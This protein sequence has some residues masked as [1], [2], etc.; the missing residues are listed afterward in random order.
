MRTD[1][2]HILVLPCH[3]M[4]GHLPITSP[5]EPDWTRLQRHVSPWQHLLKAIG[6]QIDQAGDRL[7]WVPTGGEAVDWGI[8]IGRFY[9]FAPHRHSW[10]WCYLVWL[11]HD[12]PSARWAVADTAWKEDLEPREGEERL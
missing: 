12:S 5:T 8:V 10:Q 4:T 9:G 11:D 6:T 2:N 1:S 7:Q 3:P